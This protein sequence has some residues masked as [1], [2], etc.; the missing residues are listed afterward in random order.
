MAR[1]HSGAVRGAVSSTVTVQAPV[2]GWTSD[3][4]FIEAQKGTAVILDNWV[5][6]AEAVRLRRG[7]VQHA[8]GI[9]GPVKHLMVYEGASSS[10]MF[11]ARSNGTIYDAT[12]AGAASSSYSTSRTVGTYRHT[13]FSTSGGQFLYCVNGADAPIY[14]NGSAWTA[15]TITGVT[16]TELTAV[17]PHQ[18][19]LWFLRTNSTNAYYLPTD[20]ISGAVNV[21]PVGGFMSKGGYLQAIATWT[22]D[23]GTGVDDL[24]VLLSSEGEAIVYAGTD[25]ASVNTWALQG[26]YNIGKPIGRN[27]VRKVGGDVAIVSEHGVISLQSALKSDLA[28]MQDKALTKN[29]RTAYSQAVH[30]AATIDGW[31]IE[32]YPRHQIALVNIPGSGSDVTQQFVYNVTTGAWSR[33]K[34]YNANCWTLFDS[35]LYFGTEDGLVCEADSGGTDDGRPIEATMLPAFDSLGKPGRLKHVKMIRPIVASTAPPATVVSSI[36][37]AVDYEKSGFKPV[38]ANITGSTAKWGTAV[39]GSAV[40]GGQEEVMTKWRT[41]GN[42]GTAVSPQMDVRLSSSS[43]VSHRVIGFDIVYE[44]GG[45]L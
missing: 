11:A 45:V 27:C 32:T 12:S 22:L 40:W 10:K 20:S 34:G 18:N 37:C 41:G 25:P 5:A 21:L 13:M 28:I 17:C 23:A 16:A 3:E 2:K 14:Y 30:R 44:V 8:T 9:G 26:V 38:T 7:Y 31:E 19:R 42:I 36:A 1:P 33:F 43:E 29:I 15:P 6:E 39:W 4:S 24:L 35:K